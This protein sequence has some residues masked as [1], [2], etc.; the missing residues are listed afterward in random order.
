[1]TRGAP[2]RKFAP[3]RKERAGKV[4]LHRK[5]SSPLKSR[6]QKT[7]ETQKIEDGCAE[8]ERRGETGGTVLTKTFSMHWGAHRLKERKVENRQTL[9]WKFRNPQENRPSFRLLPGGG[10]GGRKRNSE[11]EQHES[12]FTEVVVRRVLRERQL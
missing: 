12:I 11:K 8:S 4:G 5:Q 7:P 10:G 1:M 6:D 9:Q 3:G 2:Q